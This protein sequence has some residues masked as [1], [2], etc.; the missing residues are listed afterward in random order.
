MGRPAIL[1]LPVLPSFARAGS[2]DY[3]PSEPT[4]S[5]DYSTRGD[6]GQVN[7]FYGTGAYLFLKT[8]TADIPVYLQR[9]GWQYQGSYGQVDLPEGIPDI[10]FTGPFD[11]AVAH[12]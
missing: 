12:Q 7:Q 10:R 5:V 4:W 8:P 9:S 1:T 2:N 11:Q 3:E 6:I